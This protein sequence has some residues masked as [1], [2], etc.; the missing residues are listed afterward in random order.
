METDKLAEFERRYGS[1]G[2]WAALFRR[3]SGF[4]ETTLGRSVGAKG[5]YLVTDAWDKAESFTLFK[6]DF[7]D[8]YEELDKLCETLTIEE[9][10]VGNFEV[11]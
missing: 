5:H 6:K 8:A 9:K 7:H 10:H 11:I 2:D 4:R 3:A 1:H